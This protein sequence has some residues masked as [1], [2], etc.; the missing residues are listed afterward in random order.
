MTQLS[1]DRLLLRQWHGDDFEPIAEFWGDPEQTQ[2][3]GEGHLA[4]HEAWDWLV[5]CSWRLGHHWNG[6]CLH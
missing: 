6:T 5:F 3:L 1:T 4:R 2:Y